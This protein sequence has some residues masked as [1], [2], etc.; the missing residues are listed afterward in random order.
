MWVGA[1]TATR[2]LSH[3]QNGLD[4]DNDRNGVSAGVVSPAQLRGAT[5]IC[6][7]QPER[8]VPEYCRGRAGQLERRGGRTD[9]VN[10]GRQV[11]ESPSGDE[12]KLFKSSQLSGSVGAKS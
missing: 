7:Y 12:V 11:C 8:P 10:K 4:F 1:T 6:T 3:E 9:L 5:W 2:E